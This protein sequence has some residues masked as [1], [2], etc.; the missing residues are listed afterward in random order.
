MRPVIQEDK[1]G[2]GLASVATLAGVTYQ[3]VKTQ[4]GLLGINVED[5]K[6]WSDT[7]YIR[8]LLAS[9]NISVSRQV[10]TF[11]SWQH[12]PPLA[13]LA[14]KWH[15]VHHRTFWHWVVF[16]RGPQGP[17]ILDSKRELRNHGRTDFGRIK[18]KWFLPVIN[19]LSD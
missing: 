16:Y 4:A 15:Q 13:L 2:C 5:P 18:P 6:L 1:T 7:R 17:I 9:Y 10:S 19:S 12:L 3:Q 11:Q 8:K 14:I